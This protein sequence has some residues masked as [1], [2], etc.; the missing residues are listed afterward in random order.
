MDH[1]EL[2]TQ[3]F[4]EAFPNPDRIGC[5]DDEAVE[6]LAQSGPSSNDPV[7]RHVASCSE[8]YREY[9]HYCRDEEE[10]K[11]RLPSN[12]LKAKLGDLPCVAVT[13]V[14]AINRRSRNTSTRSRSLRSCRCRTRITT[15]R[16]RHTNPSSGKA[17][18]RVNGRWCLPA[19]VWCRSS[20]KN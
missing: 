14:G 16:P 12:S 10:R 5:P 17:G 11:A 8:C 1:R 3:F 2:L 15:S 19:G 4:L 7:L 6:P 20:L 9:Q 18:N 13:S